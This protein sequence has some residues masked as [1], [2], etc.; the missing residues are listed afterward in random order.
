[1]RRMG[2]EALLQHAHSPAGV[3]GD[4]AH[5]AALRR[6]AEPTGTAAAADAQRVR[7]FA[8]PAQVRRRPERSSL[9][10]SAAR[11]V[12]APRPDNQ[13]AGGGCRVGS[14]LGASPW[15]SSRLASVALGIRDLASKLAHQLV[16]RGCGGG[17]QG[18]GRLQGLAG[19]GRVTAA[20]AHGMGENG[21]GAAGPALRG[22][23]KG[24]GHGRGTGAGAEAFLSCRHSGWDSFTAH[25]PVFPCASPV[26]SP[27]RSCPA[28]PGRGGGPWTAGLWWPAADLAAPRPAGWVVG[29]LLLWPSLNWCCWPGWP[30]GQR[31]PAAQR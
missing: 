2:R 4:R 14:A 7:P 24:L 8:V 31:V 18:P 16:P 1:M 19:R 10:T 17:R 21:K 30:A 15:S 25:G 20:E 28:P 27:C 13:P 22:D 12:A 23:G 5:R 26:S 3:P 11:G 29:S 6:L 9:S